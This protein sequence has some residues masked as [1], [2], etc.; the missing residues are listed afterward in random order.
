[1]ITAP[2]RPRAAYAPSQP[3]T[4]ASRVIKHSE[5][6]AV[7]VKLR[8]LKTLMARN[9]LKDFQAGIRELD[10]I[11]AGDEW[12]NTLLFHAV[13]DGKLEFVRVLLDNGAS[14]TLENER[15]E[16]AKQAAD[17][18]NDHQDEQRKTIYELLWGPPQ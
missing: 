10:D 9:N 7:N 18:F 17:L 16:S 1:M 12:G 4:T 6:S 15:H 3:G 5:N 11:D 8:N 14:P 2:G 13:K